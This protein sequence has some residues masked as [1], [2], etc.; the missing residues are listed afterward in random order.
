[1]QQSI[2]YPALDLK[3]TTSPNRLVGLWGLMKGFRLTYLGAMASLA[4]AT[5]AKTLTYLLLAY[6]VDDI[7]TQSQPTIPFYLVALGFVGLAIVQGGFT[8]VS[9]K[10]AARSAEGVIL[11]LRNYLFDHIQR[12]PF[13][14]HDH[15]KTGELIQRCTSDVDAIRRFFSEQAIEVGRVLLLFVINFAALLSINVKLA[16]LS[17][18]SFPIVFAFSTFM[19]KKIHVAYDAHQEQEGVLSSTLQENLTGVRVVKAFARQEFETNKFEGVNREQFQ[20]GRRL[21]RLH[22]LYWPVLE[23]ISG[24][25][26]LFVFFMGALMV[27]DGVMTVGDYLAAAGLVIWIIWPLQGLGRLIVQTSMGLV[28]YTRIAEIINE[29][30]EEARRRGGEEAKQRSMNGN[31]SRLTPHASRSPNGKTPTPI[32]GELVFKDVSFEYD[33]SAPVLHNISFSARPGQMIALLGPT[34]SGKSSL[35]NLL[36]RFYDYT[37]GQILLDGVELRNYPLP[38]LRRQVGI[39]EQEPFLFSRTIRENIAYGVQ[40]DVTQA[41]IEAAAQAAAIHDIILTF[42]EGYDTLVGEKGVTLSGGQKQRVAIARTLL[43]DPRILVFDDAVSAVDTETE[44]IIHAAL[45][46]LRQGRTT[47]VIAHRIQTVM[48]ADL[49]LVLDKGRVVQRGRHHELMAQD[50]IYRRIY[51]LQ[52]SIEQEIEG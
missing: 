32:R 13:T 11:R 29:E 35:V 31:I 10:L 1:M 34:G 21:V 12:L 14:Y 6:F 25:Q 9:G 28:S 7:L 49:I 38:E 27:I 2:L 23:T 19:F 46:R 36:A 52:A 15:T 37:G 42:P 44:A 33:A 26:M 41:E 30:R 48:R 40:R 8:F 39:V 47:F 45:E 24:M 50:G 18:I 20:R 16:W 17:V 4:I 22:A 51:N 3:E 5:T 43:K